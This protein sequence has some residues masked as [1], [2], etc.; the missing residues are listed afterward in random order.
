MHSPFQ[1]NT[2]S[3][4]DYTKYKQM[5]EDWFWDMYFV[6]KK[7]EIAE[8]MYSIAEYMEL[9]SRWIRREMGVELF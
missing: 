2:R 5:V 7:T 6:L 1:N 3:R 9:S 8:D 4:Q